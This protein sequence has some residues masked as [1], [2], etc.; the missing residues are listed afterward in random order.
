MYA[1]IE[2]GGK[3]YRVQ[4]GD[5]VMVEKLPGS[6][7]DDVAFDK[8]LLL[9]DDD[10]VAVGRPTVEGARVTGVIVEHGQGE[11]LII[12]KFRRRKNYRR[13]TGHRQLFTAVK[14]RDV[15]VP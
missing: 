7:G 1:V 3:Q 15:V 5:T 6:T 10:S 2:T 14:I 4:P 11:K 9:S 8:V 13:K 12:Y